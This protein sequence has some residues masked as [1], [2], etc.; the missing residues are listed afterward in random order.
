[1]HEEIEMTSRGVALVTGAS[2]GVGRAVSRQLAQAGY[3]VALLAR[4][5]AG[6]SGVAKEIIDA[7]ANP[8]TLQVDVSDDKA[9]S[10]AA[11][12][13]ETTLGPIDIW[14][15]NAMT[16][17]FAPNWQVEPAEFKRAIEVTFLG[18]VWGTRAAL[19]LMRPRDHGTIV[20]V[21]SALAFVAIPLQAPY[22]AAKFACR[23]FTDSV[24]AELLH[25]KSNV[26]VAMVHLPAVN[27]PQFGWCRTVF[28]RHPQPVPPIYQPELVASRIV[29]VALD[30]KR[31]VVFGSFNKLLV[32][33]GRLFPRFANQY[34]S[35]A[36]W[37]SQLTDERIDPA[38]PANLEHPVDD[39]HDAGA[40]GIFDSRADG[41]RDPSF[42][43]SLPSTGA[44]FVKALV[45]SVGRA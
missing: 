23:G 29:A 26:K 39:S 44:N 11:S 10:E 25:E 45:R 8:L 5:G 15:N 1:L 9:V 12:H 43:S 41:V 14:V 32:A 35:L 30:P 24:R 17:V 3:D 28:D 6:L 16:T 19:A 31:D 4:G 2:A 7:G 13:A 37:D 42:L 22:C 40:H 38:R 33:A 34:A 21:G 36:A 18:Q 27:T 20:N